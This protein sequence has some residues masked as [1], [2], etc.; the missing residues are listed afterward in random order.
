MTPTV[1]TVAVSSFVALGLGGPVAGVSLFGHELLILPGFLPAGPASGSHN[2]PIPYM[3][4]GA[5]VTIASQGARIETGPSGLEIV[6][7]NAQD[8]TLGL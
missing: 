6:L 5:G 4:S 8:L 3:L 7:T 2:I 1:G